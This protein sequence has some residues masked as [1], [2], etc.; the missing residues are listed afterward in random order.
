[1]PRVPTAP[2][3][4]GRT[5]P[6][7]PV[8]Q[9]TGG[10]TPSAFGAGSATALQNFGQTIQRE[11]QR[12]EV[13][14]QRL[15]AEMQAEHARNVRFTVKKLD[16]EFASNI[17]FLLDGDGT[18]ANPGFRNSRGEDAFGPKLQQTQEQIR[19]KF[20]EILQSTSDPDVRATFTDMAGSRTTR[21]L[22]TIAKHAS[23]QR[24]VAEDELDQ[25]RKIQAVNEAATDPTQ[26]GESLATIVTAQ[27][28][29]SNRAG[30]NDEVK[31]VK[32]R[33]EVSSA[34]QAT[35][36]AMMKRG[37][38]VGA[39]AIFDQ[40]KGQMDG[41]LRAQV[42]GELRTAKDLT[43]AQ[44]AA[45][46]TVL[47]FGNDESKGLAFLRKTLSGPTEKAAIADYTNRI[48]EM[49]RARQ[50]QMD[51]VEEAFSRKIEEGQTLAALA[52]EFPAETAFV[53]GDPIVKAR[54]EA[55]AKATA[56]GRRFASESDDSTF[57][58]LSSLPPENLASVNLF[59]VRHQLTEIEY[60]DLVG[61]QKAAKASVND[62]TST[63]PYNAAD[64][65]INNMMPESYGAGTQ[66]EFPAVKQLRSKMRTFVFQFKEDHG[67]RNPTVP[68]MA[69]E[70]S[71]LLLPI[72]NDPPGLDIFSNEP[73]FSTLQ[74][75]LR[76]PDGKPLTEA[77]LQFAHMPIEN[78]P[79]QL[80]DEITAEL[81][82]R[83]IKA[84]DNL[85]EQIAASQVL[86]QRD[87]QKSLF[88]I[89]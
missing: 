15:A 84:T 6:V 36:L 32:I 61:M 86:K 87:R 85:I 88:G 42:E 67:G 58:R 9:G 22:S 21:A 29:Q 65:I 46:Q 69:A 28:E 55:R 4:S 7:S 64:R 23:E 52:T 51:D 62:D 26:L 33:A 75:I 1:M 27:T 40:F 41:Q 49:K 82:K 56:E 45:D 18:S 76:G 50:K 89:K 14:N 39:Q 31:G 60:K 77:E 83:N 30:E 37:N 5:R 8:L 71:S 35:T 38:L 25:S 12:I 72:V 73:A 19:K 43:T 81:K 57:R 68:E 70:A 10:A 63:A 44:G 16:N 34:I 78:I 74:G 53:N 13:T 66:K 11:G 47:Q 2:I 54:L 20:Q 79:P 80:F 17:Q 24:R 3:A 48:S 59:A